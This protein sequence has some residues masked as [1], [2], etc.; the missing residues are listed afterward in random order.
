MRTRG[1]AI[2]SRKT[3][4]ILLFNAYDGMN[5]QIPFSGPEFSS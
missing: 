1:V 5:E 3:P 2:V 4:K